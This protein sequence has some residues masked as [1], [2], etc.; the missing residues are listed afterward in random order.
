MKMLV[1]LR[2]FKTTL[3]KENNKKEKIKINFNYIVICKLKKLLP[4][5]TMNKR[6]KIKFIEWINR[7]N[8]YD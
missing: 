6:S 2:D 7:L 4:F 1:C 5:K 8:D 3:T